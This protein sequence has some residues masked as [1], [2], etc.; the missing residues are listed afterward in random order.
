MSCQRSFLAVQAVEGRE[1]QAV[2]EREVQ[3]GAEE[4]LSR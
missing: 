1:V 2:E 3:A 4:G